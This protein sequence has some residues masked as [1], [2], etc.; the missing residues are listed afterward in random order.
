MIP[1]KIRSIPVVVAG[2]AA[3]VALAGCQSNSSP[4]PAGSG[5]PSLPGAI[6]TLAAQSKTSPNP[7]YDKWAWF[8]DTYWYVP[9]NGIYS[10]A[11]SPSDPSNFQV[12]RGQTLFHIT[13][14]FNGYW[15]GSVVV[16]LTEAL[17]PSCQYVLGQV[18][19]QGNVYM[20]MF[21][22]EN[23]EMT[24]EP[25]GEMVM[26]NNEWTMVNEMTGP[27]SKGTVSHWAYMIQT[28]QGDKIFD[29]LPFA[30]ESVPSFMSACPAGP[31]ITQ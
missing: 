19:P 21:N 15:T 22:A 4:S 1:R 31:T 12:V 11:H 9:E 24:N 29:N 7:A 8:K 20:T 2:V 14:Y 10:I 3:A 23:G 30:N 27:T 17:V 5:S 26:E 18:S 6:Q 25:T 16:K 13:D 28:K